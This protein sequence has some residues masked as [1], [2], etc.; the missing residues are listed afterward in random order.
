MRG[1]I[2]LVVSLVLS[3]GLLMVPTEG[4]AQAT[5]RVATEKFLSCIRDPIGGRDAVGALKKNTRRARM[6]ESD[7]PGTS[8]IGQRAP[9]EGL[10]H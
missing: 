5:K 10:L 6:R 2:G 8:N 9:V 3:F 1:P 4:R 7:L